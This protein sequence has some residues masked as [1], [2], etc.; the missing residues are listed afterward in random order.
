MK[1]YRKKYDGMNPLIPNTGYSYGTSDSI[2]YLNPRDYIQS[3]STP[4]NF[5]IYMIH[6]TNI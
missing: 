3:I 4:Q 6:Q 5:D 1:K 2:P